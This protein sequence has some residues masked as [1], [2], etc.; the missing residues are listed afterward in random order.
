MCGSQVGSDQ[1]QVKQSTNE[2]KCKREQTKTLN[3]KGPTKKAE[4]PQET[5]GK[6]WN[7]WNQ[8]SGEEMT[9]A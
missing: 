1:N 6:A 3:P 4:H 7:V 5:L 8:M 9:G 2:N